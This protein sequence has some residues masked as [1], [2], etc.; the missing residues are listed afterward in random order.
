MNELRVIG[1]EKTMAGDC[2]W[3]R[4]RC[5]FLNDRVQILEPHQNFQEPESGLRPWWDT[6]YLTSALNLVEPDDAQD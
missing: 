4:N 5:G 1:S 3:A 6:D 2:A